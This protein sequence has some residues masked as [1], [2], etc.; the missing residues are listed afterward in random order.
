[1]TGINIG[2][3]FHYEDSIYKVTHAADERFWAICV[4]KVGAP[5]DPDDYITYY[6][7]MQHGDLVADNAEFVRSPAGEIH[8]VKEAPGVLGLLQDALNEQTC[9]ESSQ[10]GIRTRVQ[11][12]RCAVPLRDDQ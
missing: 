8:T 2:K 7:Y 12:I 5:C 9:G 4:R 1:M 3:E 6:G 10:K 11:Q